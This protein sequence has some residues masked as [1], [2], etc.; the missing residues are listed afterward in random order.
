MGHQPDFIDIGPGRCGTSWLYENLSAHPAISMAKVKETEYFNTHSSRGDDW[1]ESHFPVGGSATGEISNNYYLDAEVARRIAAYRPDMKIIFNVRHPY[2]L[3]WSTYQFGVRRGC[4]F[5]GLEQALHEPIG[6]IMGSGYEQRLRA[7][8]TTAADN[9]TLLDAVLLER[10]LQP[11]LAAFPRE[12]IYLMIYERIAVDADSLLTGLYRFLGVDPGFRAASA[13]TVV[14][15]AVAPR[16]P[17]LSRLV[18]SAAYAL[19]TAGGHGLLGRLHRSVAIKR[20][21]YRAPAARPGT[22]ALRAMVGAAAQRAIDA[23][24]E[25]LVRIFPLLAQW[26]PE[27]VPPK[28]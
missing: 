22:D 1:Y 10:R 11:F 8:T 7:Q 17:A 9:M 18:T 3:L 2:H 20:L 27:V 26:Y 23:D 12:N 14:N 16:S 28:E 24:R 21:L 6:P 13:R 19:R 5:A 4:S 25:R 15:A